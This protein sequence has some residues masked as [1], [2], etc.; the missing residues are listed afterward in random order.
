VQGYEPAYGYATRVEKT[1]P[2]PA[3]EGTSAEYE[4]AYGYATPVAKP[5]PEPQKQIAV[6]LARR[7]HRPAGGDNRATHFSKIVL[8]FPDKPNIEM[9]MCTITWVREDRQY[10]LFCNRDERKTRKRA[11]PPAVHRTNDVSFL[12]P[13]DGDAGGTWIAANES[14]LTLT[15]LNY[16]HASVAVEP[17]AVRSR[18]LLVAD[19]VTCT[20]LQEIEDALRNVELQQYNPF[21]LI[22]F[23]ASDDPLRSRWDGSILLHDRLSD[24]DLPLTTSAFEPGRVAQA[25]RKT[26]S[27]YRDLWGGISIDMLNAYHR[28]V[29]DE[30]SACAV[31]MDRSDSSTVSFTHVT[32]S[33]DEIS[34]AYAE[35]EGRT[36]TF[37]ESHDVVLPV[38]TEV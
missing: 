32:I 36:G 1:Q 22:S 9:R 8:P 15:L 25:R 19:L 7:A 31:C 11:I 29:E 6:L 28:S 34:M 30:D 13:I 3:Q 14:G 18:G 38:A 27:E 23:S 35:V 4:P 21:V 33:P 2:E 24:S 17:P 20:D 12:A 16:Y 5:Q 37:G 26:F 10:D